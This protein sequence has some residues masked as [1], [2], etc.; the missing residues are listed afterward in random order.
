MAGFDH[1]MYW[2]LAPAGKSRSGEGYSSGFDDPVREYSSQLR[3]EGSFANR[4]MQMPGMMVKLAEYA[5]ADRMTE[6]KEIYDEIGRFYADH[7]DDTARAVT[8]Q[9]KGDNFLGAIQRGA[10]IGH[11]RMYDDTPVKTRYGEFTVGQLF[12]PDGLYQQTRDGELRSQY[13][14]EAVVSAMDGDD[15]E[16][17]TVVASIV[18]PS[19]RVVRPG[20]KQTPRSQAAELAHEVAT[21]WDRDYGELGAE[22]IRAAVGEVKDRYMD[23]GTAV[24]AF[25]TLVGGAAER[26]RSGADDD[27]VKAVHHIASSYRSLLGQT[28]GAPDNAKV[29][30]EASRMLAMVVSGAMA[31]DPGVDLDDPGVRAA[32]GEVMNTFAAAE[33]A[34]VPLLQ[35]MQSGG[36]EFSKSVAGY[37][38][39]RSRGIDPP[40]GNHL[41]QVVKANDRIGSLLSSGWA[42]SDAP[43]RAN[44]QAGAG[45]AGA[46]FGAKSTSA[47]LNFASVAVHKALLT[48]VAAGVSHGMREPEA[49]QSVMSGRDEGNT[50]YRV[51]DALEDSMLIP[52][53]AAL[54]VASALFS[55]MTAGGNSPTGLEQAVADYA[56][57]S[58][59]DDSLE[60]QDAR[61]SV[62]EWYAANL[63]PGSRAFDQLIDQS[64]VLNV[65]ND[66]LV[67]YG[68][69]KDSAAR[70]NAIL[71]HYRQK[72]YSLAQRGLSPVS[73][74]DGVKNVGRYYTVAGFQDR[75]TGKTFSDYPE[76]V[77]K[78]IESK[79]AKA[80]SRA[81]AKYL[82][83][84]GVAEGDLD[85]AEQPFSGW[86]PPGFGAVPSYGQGSW[87]RSPHL[88]RAAQEQ[89]RKIYQDQDAARLKIMEETA[90]NASSS[91]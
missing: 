78:A 55:R 14:S 57:G 64:G 19:L 70:V 62:R 88:F 65:L 91:I 80:I 59:V 75:D 28:A 24:S 46:V 8:I 10:L 16:K 20:E 1:A 17:K 77:Q 45:D 58:T 48:G 12:G 63:G 40:E 21:N 34:G 69:G 5:A 42:A 73:F 43:V 53:Y 9:P 87:S 27:P 74:L 41:W 11:N 39:T 60:E 2:D 86:Q 61:K 4:V 26:L 66:P 18:D 6:A 52:R 71:Q 72:M 37:V 49:F 38:Q 15:K 84:V 82:P 29:P 50:I 23:D 89:L 47:G 44:P 3:T 51:A 67:G 30:H 7:V 31:S 83:V 33:R 85:L 13:F 76:D 56:F 22:A 81:L 36:T 90:K 25:R 54:G 68:G 79:D 32:M 35:I